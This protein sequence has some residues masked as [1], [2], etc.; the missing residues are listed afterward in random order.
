MG[1]ITILK[2]LRGLSKTIK[3]NT[4]QFALFRNSYLPW[5]TYIIVTHGHTQTQI[6]VC[7]NYTDE[8]Q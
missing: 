2:L 7:H 5:N 8:A 4:E 1:K 3:D 6:S